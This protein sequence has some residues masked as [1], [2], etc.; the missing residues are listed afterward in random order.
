MNLAARVPCDP[1]T[2]SRVEN[3]ILAPDSH[4]AAV[5]DEAFPQA[6][7]FFGR[8]YAESRDW[9]ARTFARPRP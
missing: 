9:N 6:D 8:F 2:V 4:L 1:S 5:C 3:G 7:G